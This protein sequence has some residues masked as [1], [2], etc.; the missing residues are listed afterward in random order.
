VDGGDKPETR[1][2]DDIISL[3]SRA[4]PKVEEGRAAST[5]RRNISTPLFAK[6]QRYSKTGPR[7]LGDSSI[8]H[9]GFAR[10]NGWGWR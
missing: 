9:S 6:D 7:P 3:D 4:I 8:N 10:L 1:D 5:M 2:G